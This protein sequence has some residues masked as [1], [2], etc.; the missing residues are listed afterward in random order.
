VA[1]R[2][3]IHSQSMAGASVVHNEPNEVRSSRIFDV[4]LYLFLASLQLMHEVTNYSRH[5]N[6]TRSTGCAEPSQRSIQLIQTILDM[7]GPVSAKLD[8]KYANPHIKPAMQV[9]ASSTHDIHQDDVFLHD[10]G[11]IMDWVSVGESIQQASATGRDKTINIVDHPSSNLP[12]MAAG[13]PLTTDIAMEDEE[14]SGADG[15]PQIRS[16]HQLDSSLQRNFLS[17]AR[18]IMADPVVVNMLG[19]D[20][21]LQQLHELIHIAAMQWRETNFGHSLD[22]HQNLSFTGDERFQQYNWALQP[23][24]IQLDED[25]HQQLEALYSLHS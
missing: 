13:I 20:K 24:G 18:L 16:L 10:F 1:T 8:A 5:P 9:A 12:S 25:Y 3:W 6:T 17:L 4:L 19:Y 23:Q 14:S 2:K 11:G 15:K 21:G 7:A 22:P